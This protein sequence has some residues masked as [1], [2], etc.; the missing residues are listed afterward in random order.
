MERLGISPSSVK[1]TLA[2]AAERLG[3]LKSNGTVLARSPLSNVVELEALVVGITGKEAM[4]AALEQLCEHE[5]KLD[6]DELARLIERARR[7]RQVVDDCRLEAA[8]IAFETRV[9]PSAR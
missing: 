3:R 8:R 6:A 9:Q 5:P 4:W 1:D 7:Q 2:E